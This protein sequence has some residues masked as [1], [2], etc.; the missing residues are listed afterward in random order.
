[1]LTGLDAAR[2]WLIL[3]PPLPNTVRG[4]RK[5]ASP[6]SRLLVMEGTGHACWVGGR[7]RSRGERVLRWL[8]TTSRAAGLS[9]SRPA[10]HHTSR[11]P[12]SY[13]AR[14]PFPALLLHCSAPGR[15]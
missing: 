15:A 12:R 11:I 6:R 9:R 5:C 2:A 14:P 13:R 10:P 4:P 8:R 7:A 1:M 3:P